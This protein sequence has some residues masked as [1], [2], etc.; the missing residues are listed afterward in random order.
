MV[1]PTESILDVSNNMF[2]QKKNN[3][4]NLYNLRNANFVLLSL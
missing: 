3:I 2:I 1:S 4:K